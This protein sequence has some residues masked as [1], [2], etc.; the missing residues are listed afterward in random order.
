MIMLLL[1]KSEEHE[2]YNF[3]LTFVNF[4]TTKMKVFSDIRFGFAL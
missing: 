1:W 4:A 2:D 3:I